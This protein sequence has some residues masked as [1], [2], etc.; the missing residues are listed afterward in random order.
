MD[1]NIWESKSGKYKSKS[2][3]LGYDQ[4]SKIFFNTLYGLGYLFF[5][6]SLKKETQEMSIEMLKLKNP[7]FLQRFSRSEYEN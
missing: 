5:F 6:N 3:Q 7:L 1:T 2:S 4:D